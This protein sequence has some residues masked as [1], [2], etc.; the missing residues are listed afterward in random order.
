MW[1]CSVEG[2]LR[3]KICCFQSI[4]NHVNGS[5]DSEREIKWKRNAAAVC[6]FVSFLKG[7][8]NFSGA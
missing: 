6:L 7:I 3:D 4:C 2:R 1:M 5:E 8:K